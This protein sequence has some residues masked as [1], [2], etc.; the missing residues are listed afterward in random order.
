VALRRGTVKGL[1]GSV[2]CQKIRGIYW[3]GP[4]RCMDGGVIVDPLL[5]HL[6]GMVKYFNGG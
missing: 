2:G 3:T 6:T 1:E 5:L 4:D